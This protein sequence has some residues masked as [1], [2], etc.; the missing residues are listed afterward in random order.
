MTQSIQ[1]WTKKI[2]GKQPSKNFT[3]SIFEYFLPNN[4]ILVSLLFYQLTHFWPIFPFYTSWKYQEAKVFLIFLGGRKW[5]HWP[6]VGQRTQLPA[7]FKQSKLCFRKPVFCSVFLLDSLKHIF[8]NR[9]ANY[10]HQDEFKIKP[11]MV[12]YFQQCFSR[13]IIQ[14]CHL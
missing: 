14:D 13:S 5:E 6:E 9:Q 7:Y 1:E 3:W 2:C 4:S 12:H 8:R 10:H 11:L